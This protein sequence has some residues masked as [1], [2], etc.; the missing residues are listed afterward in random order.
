M[1]VEDPARE[2]DERGGCVPAAR[3]G[4][5]LVHTGRARSN[6]AMGV[7]HMVASPSAISRDTAVSLPDSVYLGQHTHSHQL[8]ET[9]VRLTKGRG[10]ARDP[11]AHMHTD[12][13]K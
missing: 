1:H 10:Q 4:S 6:T 8:L 12:V 3:Q 2:T 7:P 13:P 11:N 9:R 5:P